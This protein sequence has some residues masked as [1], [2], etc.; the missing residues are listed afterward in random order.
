MDHHGQSAVGAQ[1]TQSAI[2]ILTGLEL[3]SLG[4]LASELQDLPVV[5][6]PAPGLQGHTTMLSFY[7]QLWLRL[8]SPHVSEANPLPTE[9]R[10]QVISRDFAVRA[11]TRPASP[12][13]RGP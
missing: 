12:P 10:P 4:W 7:T 13:S 3:P 2:D 1:L 5:V 6:S 9:L 8:T 11:R